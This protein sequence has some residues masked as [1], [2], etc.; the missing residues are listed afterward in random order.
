MRH[1]TDRTGVA[2]A[3]T[4]AEEGLGELRFPLPTHPVVFFQPES[5]IGTAPFWDGARAG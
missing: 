4:A 1:T 2:D 5:G 3:V